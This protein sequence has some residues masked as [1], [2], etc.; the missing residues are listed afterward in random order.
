MDTSFYGNPSHFEVKIEMDAHFSLSMEA[1]PIGVTQFL[2]H[3]TSMYSYFLYAERM[4]KKEQNEPVDVF[5]NTIYFPKISGPFS[6][7]PRI[8]MKGITKS[9]RRVGDNP[10]NQKFILQVDSEFNCFGCHVELFCCKTIGKLIP[11]N[12]SFHVKSSTTR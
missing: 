11:K 5:L 3:A 9:V 4:A 8:L 12:D 2:E 1:D 6:H 10:K 7:D